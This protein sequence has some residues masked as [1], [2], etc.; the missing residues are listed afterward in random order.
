MVY[1]TRRNEFAADKYS[2]DQGYGLALRMA[3]IGIHI[4]NA[5]NLNPDSL[6]A[7]LKFTHPALVERLA[8]IDRFMAQNV[9]ASGNNNPEDLH[10]AYKALWKD[11]IISRH[12]EDAY[13]RQ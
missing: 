3:L 1:M 5:A 11:K 6:Y 9:R 7:G 8:G 4:N 2:V 13:E 10:E 12:G